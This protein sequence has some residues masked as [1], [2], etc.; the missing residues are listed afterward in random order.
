VLC[1][2]W[3]RNAVRPLSRQLDW[4]DNNYRRAN[5]GFCD[6]GNE[7]AEEAPDTAGHARC[8]RIGNNMASARPHRS[9]GANGGAC[10]AGATAARSMG[11]ESPFGNRN[12]K[13]SC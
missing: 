4:C 12:E 11:G 5:G 1:H 6:A 3:T 13:V 2:G 9:L 7:V 8:E 10:G